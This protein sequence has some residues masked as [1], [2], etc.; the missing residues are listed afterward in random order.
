MIQQSHW[1]DIKN[2]LELQQ[3]V[4]QS[5]SRLKGIITKYC[6]HLAIPLL[7][8]KSLETKEPITHFLDPRTFEAEAGSLTVV[9]IQIITLL[10]GKDTPQGLHA[11]HQ[12]LVSEQLPLLPLIQAVL[13]EEETTIQNYAT[14]FELDPSLFLYIISAPLQPFMEEIA[15]QVSATFYERWW[16]S[17]CPICGRKPSVAR[18]RKRRRY[19]M[20]HFC[21]A[22]YL[23]DY[24]I[25]VNCGNKDPYTLKFLSIDEKPEFQIDFCTKCKNYLKVI[26]DDRLTEGIPRF[27]EDI[28][29]L[30]LDVEAKKAGLIRVVN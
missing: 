1:D 7:E 3:K 15:R 8:K 17:P 12:Q 29:T 18:I 4:L 28:L 9:L 24:F 10:Q 19:L 22:E 11:L 2:Y 26:N 5:Q 30:N 25:C 27:L 20:C 23:S 6:S 16:R 21:G 13:R 14:E